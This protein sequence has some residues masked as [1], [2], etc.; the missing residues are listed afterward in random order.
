MIYKFLAP[1]KYH[2]L[3]RNLS[4][5]TVAAKASVSRLTLRQAERGEGNP[6]LKT[7]DRIAGSLGM[8]LLVLVV[9]LETPV[10]SSASTVAVSLKACHDGFETWPLHLMELVDAFR[11]TRDLRLLALPPVRELDERLKALLASTVVFLCEEA[12]VPS[13]T[14]AVE[15]RFLPKP[16]FLSE[17]ESLKAMAIRDSPLAFRRNNIFV[18]D[19]F[20]VRI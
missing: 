12:G 10:D 16:W 14:W 19:N 20:L 3:N 6:T 18:Q 8:E 13:P 4:E 11:K 9:P 1:L 5:E 7:L 2:R 15:P 17:T